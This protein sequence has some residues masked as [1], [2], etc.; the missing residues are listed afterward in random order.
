MSMELVCTKCEAKAYLLIDLFNVWAATPS[1]M[2]REFVETTL[3]S[4][5]FPG[6]KR[7]RSACGN[8]MM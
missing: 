4:H 2:I 6:S 5:I 8:P 7:I 3:Q 1:A